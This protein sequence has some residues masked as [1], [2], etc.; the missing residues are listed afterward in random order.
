MV[1]P[2]SSARF[3]PNITVL[4]LFER[5]LQSL[6][7]LKVGLKLCLWGLQTFFWG[8]TLRL[9]SLRLNLLQSYSYTIE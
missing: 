3:E 1:T 8:D 4:V 7:F 2:N 9:G 6:G 5:Q